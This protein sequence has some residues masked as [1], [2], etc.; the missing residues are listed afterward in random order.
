MSEM[1][2]ISIL[3]VIVCY[4]SRVESDKTWLVKLVMQSILLLKY[5]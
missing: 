2:W 3:P 1:I 5:C 4:G